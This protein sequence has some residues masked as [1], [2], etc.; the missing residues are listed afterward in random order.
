[1]FAAMDLGLASF[2]TPLGTCAVVWSAR[3]IRG[4]QLPEASPAA[5]LARAHAR[6]PGAVPAEPPAGVRDAIARMTRALSGDPCDLAAIELDMEGLSPF[7]R[8]VY[9]AARA[10]CAGQTVSYGDLAARVG[11]AGGSR[12]VGQAMGK[13]PFPIVVPCHRVLSSTGKPGGFSAYG[14]ATTKAQMLAAEGVTVGAGLDFDPVAARAHVCAKDARLS[15]IIDRVG[16]FRLAVTE[17][18]DTFDEL[19][20]SIVFQQL[21]GRAAATIHGRVKALFP[22]ARIRPDALLEMS[23]AKLRGAGLSRN[24]MLALQD[25]SRKTL[26]G[27]V[28]KLG[29][30]RKLGDDE[31]VERLTQVRGIGRWTVEMLLIFRLGRPDVLPVDDYGVRKGFARTYNKKD[32]PAPK[33]LLEFG[34]RW[35]PYRTVASWYFWRAV[36]L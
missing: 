6:F 27:T 31:I 25:L 15:R 36:E 3:G 10:V 23:E 2:D 26:D 22:R 33:V 13:N 5:T 18:H 34:E 9:D 4:V 29:K 14:G 32:L 24:K 16:P 20:R 19:A 7:F 30:L 12:A 21:A 8:K 11:S 1:M 17:A 28:P 35:R